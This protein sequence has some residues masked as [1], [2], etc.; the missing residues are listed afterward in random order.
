M[1][2]MANASTSLNG[3]ERWRWARCA[4]HH[5]RHVDGVGWRSRPRPCERGLLGGEG[6]VEPR[7][8]R[9]EIGRLDGRAG[10]DAQAR[11]ARRDRR[12][13]RRRRRPCR[14][15]TTIALANAACASSSSAVTAGSTIDQAHRGVGALGR[16]SWRGTRPTSVFATQSASTLKLA[17]ARACMALRPPIDLPHSIASTASSMQSIETV[18]MVAPSKM[19]S[20]SLPPLVRRKILGSGRS[21]L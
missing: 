7:R 18:L 21:G 11:S 14:A 19:S 15:A 10:P 1:V 20:I 16:R 3:E 8:Q 5:L 17:S 9:R 12:R 4:N 13:C 6:P 2:V